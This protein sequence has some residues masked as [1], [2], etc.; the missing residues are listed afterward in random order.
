MELLAILEHRHD[1][2]LASDGIALLSNV[3]DIVGRLHFLQQEVAQ[4]KIKLIYSLGTTKGLESRATMLTSVISRVEE[5]NQIFPHG[6][7]V[8]E[9]DPQKPFELAGCFEPLSLEF[10]FRGQSEAVAELPL[11]ATRGS[12]GVDGL[13]GDLKHRREGNGSHYVLGDF[14]GPGVKGVRVFIKNEKYEKG[15]RSRLHSVRLPWDE[16]YAAWRRCSTGR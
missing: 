14:S 7:V 8:Y 13:M 16:V 2:I 6:G 12:G 9:T 1:H 11:F 4:S 10:Y 3:S 15:I 5:A